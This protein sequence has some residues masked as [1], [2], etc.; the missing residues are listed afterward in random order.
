VRAALA[1]GLVVLILTTTACGGDDNGSSKQAPAAAS[2]PE[3]SAKVDNPFFPLSSAPVTIFRGREGNSRTRDANHVLKKR[4]RVAGVPVTVVEV[5]EFENGELVERT[6]DYYAQR[7][8]GSVWYF[9]ERVNNYEDGKLVHHEGQWLAGKNKAKPGLFM[10]SNPK[11]GHSFQQERAPGVAE[12]QSKVVAAGLNVTTPAGS[13][14]KC[15]RPGTT[16]PWTR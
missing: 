8:D 16:L 1:G 6:L 11:V 10:P 15:S 3:F 5:K 9:G 14:D 7:R 12:D 2:R 13:F 4:E